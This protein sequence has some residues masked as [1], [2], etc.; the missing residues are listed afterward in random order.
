MRSKTGI[1][2]FLILAL[3]RY[4]QLPVFPQV[5]GAIKG[6]VLGKEAGKPVAEAKVIIVSAKIQSIKYEVITDK[7]GFFYKSGLQPGMYQVS[8]EKS[9]FV[10]AVTNLRLTIGEQRDITITLEIIKQSTNAAMSLITQAETMLNEGK[11][12][13]VIDKITTASNSE[14]LNYLLYYYRAVALEKVEDQ[15]KALADYQ[16]ALE[17]KPDF[18]LVLTNIGKLYARTGNYQ[19]AIEFYKKA[20][21]T[22]STDVLTLYNYGVCLINVGNNTE[23]KTV[24]EKLLAIDPAYPDAHYQLGIICLGLGDT[25][26]AKEYLNKFIHLDPENSNVPLARDILKSLN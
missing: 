11:F 10:P 25:A 2:I 15:Q 4:S 8:F 24:F 13:A 7:N 18:F 1:K 6:H 3:L 19:K 16:K 26:K 23:A 14:P 5:L 9:G 20:L 17:L 22:G 21:E 12:Q